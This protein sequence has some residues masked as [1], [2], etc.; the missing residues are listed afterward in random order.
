MACSFGMDHEFRSRCYRSLPDAPKRSQALREQVER[1][2]RLARATTDQAV[3]RRLLELA[4]KTARHWGV[5]YLRCIFHRI[6]PEAALPASAIRPI[7]I[8]L[9]YGVLA[10]ENVLSCLAIERRES[11]QQREIN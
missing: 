11:Q 5:D 9:G 6:A 2:R 8:A 4:E 1:C 10:Y 7:Q 3:S